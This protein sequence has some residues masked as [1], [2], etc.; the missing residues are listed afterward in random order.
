MSES[1][2]NKTD[3]A[4]KLIQETRQNA[5]NML[6]VLQDFENNFSTS[7]EMASKAQALR[8][9]TLNNLD[10]NKKLNLKSRETL[11]KIKQ[12]ST[13]SK[14]NLELSKFDIEE[15]LKVFN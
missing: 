2:K 9:D 3:E 11:E 6:S 15:S 8:T 13:E 1:A 7:K 5:T 4:L 10:Q 12:L 14:S